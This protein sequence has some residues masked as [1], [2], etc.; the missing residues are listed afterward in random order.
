M[1][2]HVRC[3][4]SE[5]EGE[6]ASVA[7]ERRARASPLLRR[8]AVR[9][10]LLDGHAPSGALA[11]WATSARYELVA[12]REEGGAGEWEGDVGEVGVARARSA[13]HAHVWP[14]LRRR[15]AA[16][17]PLFYSDDEE[18]SDGGSCDEEDEESAVERAEAFAEAL[19]VLGAVGA[20][21]MVGAV[22]AVGEE[23]AAGEG[24]ERGVRRER[25]ERLVAAFCRALGHDLHL[26]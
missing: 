25:A 3:T 17:A 9:L 26:C 8:G 4:Q 22:G 7:E 12:L 20:G 16:P 23:G 1:I 14:G 2:R 19:G 13:L 6:G 18:S 5:G 10:A 24:E 15:G 21:G 11:S